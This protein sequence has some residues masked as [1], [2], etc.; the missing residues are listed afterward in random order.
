MNQLHAISAFDDFN[1]RQLQAYAAIS[2]LSL[3]EKF[4]I[5]HKEIDQ[6]IFHLLAMLTAESLPEW[7]RIGANLSV[8]GRGDPLPMAVENSIKGIDTVSFREI[9]E[10][11]VE[12]GIIDMYGES[13]NQPRNFLEKCLR[14]ITSHGV[15]LP[16]PNAL[17]KLHAGTAPW[18][19]PVDPAEFDA[20]I[21]T[22]G[23]TRIV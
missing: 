3:C 2:M 20:L 16:S 6:L 10:S 1:I 8:S 23:N 17:M 18:G 9:M 7:E 5:N 15:E 4:K 22:L 21:R 14:K 12:I 13:T 11:C 19:N